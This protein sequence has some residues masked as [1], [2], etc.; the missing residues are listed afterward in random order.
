M[1]SNTCFGCLNTFYYAAEPE[2]LQLQ[3]RLYNLSFSR[4]HEVE[5]LSLFLSHSFYLVISKMLHTRINEDKTP[6]SKYVCV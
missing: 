5:I 4:T 6:L 3:R 2:K 1:Q